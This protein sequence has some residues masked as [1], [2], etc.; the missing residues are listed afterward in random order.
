MP[1]M[2]ELSFQMAELPFQMPES[3]FKWILSQ[4]ILV[5]FP[6]GKKSEHPEKT[7]DFR[8]S[9]DGLFSHESIVRRLL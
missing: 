4:P 2:A 6:C 1:K 7:H 3:L 8:Q 5:N 9:V